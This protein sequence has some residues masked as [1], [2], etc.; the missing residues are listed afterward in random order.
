MPTISG[1]GVSWIEGVRGEEGTVPDAE[2]EELLAP[3][4]GDGV[5]V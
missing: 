3:A 5:E 1:G 2:G 4:A